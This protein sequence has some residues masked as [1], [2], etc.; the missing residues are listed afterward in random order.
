MLCNTMAQNLVEI[1]FDSVSFAFY[2]FAAGRTVYA[3]RI[4][5]H[6]Y[7]SSNVNNVFLIFHSVQIAGI[8]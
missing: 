8:G 2:P 3:Q 1:G 6:R 7:F 4:R 5:K